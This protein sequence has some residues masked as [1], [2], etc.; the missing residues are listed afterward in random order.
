MEPLVPN[1]FLFKLEFALHYFS[2]RPPLN[3]TVERWP[4]ATLLEPFGMMDGYEPF[5]DVYAGWSEEGLFIGVSLSGKSSE[6][7][8]DARQYWK[9]D[10]IRVMTDTRDSRNVRRATRFCQHFYLLPAGGGDEGDDA[11]A[12][13]A[14]VRRATEDAPLANVEDLIVASKLADDGYQLTAHIPATALFGFDP[15]ENP[16]I[17]L[18][19]IVEDSE[20]GQQPLT[21]GDDLNWN[22]DP[23]TWP[24]AVLGKKA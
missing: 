10:N 5:A 1:P 3:G 21:V 13:A 14:K 9:A 20:L 23:S 4:K 11:I 7:T 24:T 22:I 17:G 18:Y 12:G 16:R 8:C 19:V 15:I 2:K 6:I